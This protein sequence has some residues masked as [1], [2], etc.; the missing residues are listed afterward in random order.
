MAY[1]G[2][3]R[4]LGLIST[5]VLARLLL[6]EDFGLVAVATSIVALLD[7][8]RFFGF[9]ANLIQLRSP[10]KDHFDTAWTFA[11]VL[12]AITGLVLAVLAPWVGD[13]YGDSRLG[14]VL[15]ALSLAAILNGLES[16]GPVAFRRE[17]QWRQ[18]FLFQS[19]RKVASVI[20]TIPLA[21]VLRNYWALVIGIIAG[22][23]AAMV[24]SYLITPHRPRFTLSAR[25]D[26]WTFSK[27][28]LITNLLTF[29]RER[30]ANLII[31]KLTNAQAVGFFIV[32]YDVTK[33]PTAELAAPINR[34][35]FPGFARIAH[36]LPRLRGAFLKLLGAMSAVVIPA[37]AGVSV[38]AAP[39]VRVCLGERW[40]AAVPAFQLLGIS[41]AITGLLANSQ[42]VYFAIGRPRLQ[43][44]LMAVF[45]AVLVPAALA[46]TPMYA[47]VGAAWAYLL[48]SIVAVPIG[49]ANVC[50]CL[51]LPVGRLIGVLW[52]PVAATFAM[53][54]AVR[55]LDAF[56]LDPITLP[57]A[58]LV[59]AL[60]VGAGAMVYGTGLAGLWLAMGRPDGAESWLL[61]TLRQ[62]LRGRG[63]ADRAA[64]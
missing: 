32:A 55:T 20:F 27:W 35:A 3:E 15:W 45:I 1:K 50:H 60:E 40:M 9:D 12:G 26:L 42:A 51:E 52:R 41:G 25:S 56:L 23:L 38:T 36:D 7:I 34:A 31:G 48:A 47:H 62:K 33:L 21:L 14:P 17:L 2:V 10:T 22:R 4:G 44:L 5:L 29:V 53:V 63:S 39:L 58:A 43:A 18:D 16:N 30:F 61:D 8:L 24:M 11:A 13:F 57:E 49:L 54:A 64:I 28:M 46:L 59:L 19:T 6:P 37:G